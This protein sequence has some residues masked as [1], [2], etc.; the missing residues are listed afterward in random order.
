MRALLSVADREGIV[1]FAR[2][3][4]ALDVDLVA[5]EG[6]REHLDAAGVQV[7][8]L[9]DITG[10]PALAGGLVRTLHPAVYAGILAR[11][12]RPDELAQSALVC[13]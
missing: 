2:E 9:S 11:R 7:A 6:T 1:E 8:A 5:T 13:V 12:D 10:T 3:L 4:Q